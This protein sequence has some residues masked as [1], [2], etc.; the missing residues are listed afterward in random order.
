MK[1]GQNYPTT[2]PKRACRTVLNFSLK[3]VIIFTLF[4]QLMDY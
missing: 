3:T 2:F 4:T 1:G